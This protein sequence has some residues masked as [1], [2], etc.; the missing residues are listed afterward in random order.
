MNTKQT[1][2]AD[3]WEAVEEAVV[4]KPKAEKMHWVVRVTLRAAWVVALV[5]PF[6]F[7]GR[8]EYAQNAVQLLIFSLAAL[9]SGYFLL[10]PKGSLRALGFC[11]AGKVLTLLVAAFAGLILLQLAP[12]P[13]SVL[14]ALSP[15]AADVYQR[16]GLPLGRLSLEASTTWAE[17]FWFAAMAL[18]GLWLVALPYETAVTSVSGFSQRKPRSKNP[19][20]EQARETD[21]VADSLQR[22]IVTVGVIC[23][24]VA[25]C[26]WAMRSEFLFGLFDP[27]RGENQIRAHFP[28]VN[29]D[30]LS[31]LLEIAIISAF[32]RLL[33]LSQLRSIRSSSAESDNLALRILQSPGKLGRQVPYALGIL[34]MVLCNVLALS[35]GGNVLVVFGLVFLYV[36]FTRLPVR[37]KVVVPRHRHERKARFFL[38]ARVLLLLKRVFVVG[39]VCFVV[40][41]FLGQTGR[42]LAANRIEYGLAAGYDESRVMLNQTSLS[43]FAS[44]SLFG[45]GLGC[46]HLA[47]TRYVPKELAGWFLD[48]AH[49][50]YLQLFAET[51]VVGGLLLL[52]GLGCVLVMT[53]R[54]WKREL[55]ATQRMEIL[56]SSVAL[57][58][59]LIHAFFDFPLHIP[60]LALVIVI[61]LSIHL[62][63]LNRAAT[64]IAV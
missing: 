22:I 61:A 26:H 8:H 12:L 11:S 33:R 24:I 51:G 55:M 56:G 37:P 58:L 44:Y 2:L 45:A 53:R 13:L 34:T 59:P 64:Y 10:R 48:F 6:F 47:A 19:L 25:L 1:R 20:A 52:S 63:L 3:R 4:L 18:A 16:T 15:N 46:W 57:L 60:A 49:N 30:H 21:A 40:L 9:F 31:V 62:R 43:V 14:G 27:G 29:P 42:D 54:A 35:R 36:M 41:F 28:F 17:L 7:G 5:F 23:S 38:S 50:D 32:S 39:A